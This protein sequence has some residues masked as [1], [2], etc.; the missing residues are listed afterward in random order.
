MHLSIKLSHFAKILYG[1]G[2]RNLELV[3]CATRGR[4]EKLEDRM[5]P[6]LETKGIWLPAYNVRGSALHPRGQARRRLADRFFFDHRFHCFIGL[7][8]V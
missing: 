6:R 5:D 7:W 2:L 1:K 3:R 4:S 8:P